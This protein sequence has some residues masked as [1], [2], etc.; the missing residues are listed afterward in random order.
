M[1]V[2]RGPST[3]GGQPNP[4]AI[5]LMITGAS[6]SFQRISS[7]D[8][9]YALVVTGTLRL[10]GLDGLEIEGT[11][12]FRVNTATGDHTFQMDDPATTATESSFVVNR[13]SFVFRATAIRIGVAGVLDIT[14]N[15]MV[16]RQPNGDLDLAITGASVDVTVDDTVVVRLGGYAAFTISSATGFRLSTFGVTTFA[17]FP[18]VAAAAASTTT[19]TSTPAAPTLFPTADLANPKNRS[20]VVY[21]T[22]SNGTGGILRVVFNDR[23]GVG[24]KETSIRDVAPEFEIWVN[25]VKSTVAI[26]TM[27]T[28]VAGLINTWDYTFSGNLFPTGG[29]S[30]VVEVRFVTGGISDNSG[31]GSFG[32]SEQFYV[33]PSESQKPGPVAVL[34]SPGNGE[35][36]TAPALNA[37]RYIDVTFTSLDGTPIRK[38]SIEDAAPEFKLVG[39]G[40]QDVALDATGAPI[41]VGLPLLISGRDAGATVVTYRFFLRDKTPNDA[42]GLFKPGTVQVAFLGTAANPA[43]TTEEY[44]GSVTDARGKN[45]VGLTQTFTLD[46]AAPGAKTQAGPISLG[47]LTLQ[48]PSV[49]IADVGFADGMLVLTISI[50]VDQASLAFGG[51]STTTPGQPT[52]TQQNSGVS[53]DLVGLQG[54]F[55]LA[56]DALGLLSGNV[57]IAPTGKW[58]IRVASLE[59]QVGNVAKLT[60]EGVVFGYTPRA[61]DAT[62]P[63]T[64]ELL[65][66]ATATITF[67]TLG[68]TGSLRP[69]DPSQGINVDPPAEGELAP[70][71]MPGLVV[72]ANGFSLGTAELA[73]GLPPFPPGSAPQPGNQLTKSPGAP[74][75][76]K[77]INL[78]GLIELDDLR[79][80]VQGLSVTFGE[81]ATQAAFTGTIY[82]ATG[83]ARLFPG[84]AINA[85]IKDRLTADDKNADLSDN[86]EALRAQLV[87]DDGEIKAFQLEIDTLEV[88]LSTFVT[89]TARDFVLDTGADAD[90]YLVS[91]LSVG[92]RIRVGGLELSGEARNFGFLGDGSFDAKANF[93]VYLG[94][95]SAT[96]DSFKWPDFLPVR[97]DAI[98][99]EWV[100]VENHPEDFV[101]VLSAS[102]TGIKGVGG[103]QFTG[104]IEGVRIAPALLAQGQFPIISIDSLGVTVKGKMFGGEIEAGL[105]GGI[106][107]L[108]AQ[109]NPIGVFDRTTPVAK[110]VFYLGIQGGFS[111]AGMAGFT[112]R[113]GLSELG[114]LQVFIN[115]EVP[116]GILLE[117]FSGLTINDFSAGVEFFKTLPSIDDPMALRGSAFGLPTNITADEWLASLQTQVANQAKAIRD[118]VAGDGFA[119]AFTSPMVITGAARIYSMYTSQAIFNGHVLVKISTDGKFLIV[120]TLNFAD[121]NISL[122]GR[123]Y[124]DLSRADEGDVTVLFLADI[125]DQARLLSL[126]GKLKMGFRNSS[127]QEV[128]FTVPAS[129]LTG[130]TTGSAAGRRREP[131]RQRRQHRPRSAE[132]DPDVG[133]LDAAV[134]HR[135]GVHRGSG[136]DDG[137]AADPERHDDL[138]PQGQRDPAGQWSGPHRSGHRQAHPAGERHH[139]GR[140]QRGRDHGRHGRRQAVGVLR[141]RRSQDRRGHRVPGRRR[142][143]GRADAGGG[144]ADQWL[145]PGPL[146]DRCRRHPAGCGL[147][148]LPRRSLQERGHSRGH[149]TGQRGDHAQLLGQGARRDRHRPGSR[150]QHR[151]ARAQRARV[152]R[153]HLH[154]P[155]G[156]HPGPGLDRRPGARVP[157]LGSGPRHGRPRRHPGPGPD[158]LAE[159]DQQL[160]LPL[161]H[162]R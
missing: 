134:L 158:Q 124:A 103:L 62:G 48:G 139:R 84:K 56:V 61:A 143:H 95:G 70:G 77:N 87:F 86:T 97:I 51:R 18:D 109:L 82:I 117:P 20:T 35:T 44:T 41:L 138:R 122:S 39:T 72:R 83:G 71:L 32:E 29:T 21:S 67:P 101:L 90:E 34:A 154:R 11:V 76:D 157:H 102:V 142:G 24:I 141:D 33:T 94:I 49:G 120:G 128:V 16:T 4:N 126:Y 147:P 79:V 92:A 131:G 146:P 125:P 15:L 111:I 1:F 140:C 150:R 25:G 81:G 123:L 80:G 85:T 26:G 112:I 63:D 37:R 38:S 96:G 14:G 53:V 114:P 6:V 110:R 30:G 104:S 9:T 45:I 31:A 133:V 27:P 36:L 119:A 74:G 99:V 148:V 42:T 13:Q 10:V 107:R 59:A 50:G 40:L 155:D 52:Q 54:T 137:L 144:H 151:R 46:A 129:D 28:P 93:G 127:G 115:V 89:L 88:N 132:E 12:D 55:D 162:H 105:V 145:Q 156:P 73:Y 153:R 23:N 5:G 100:D 136:R 135:P 113:I 64:Q 69:Y 43:W 98:G 22:F 130:G 106:M 159:R 160:H 152:D 3:I 8:G 7:T 108:D 68:V 17:L 161:L 2:G 19:T 47:P 75:T 149:R 57:R 78:F 65:R 58:G 118:G 60:A 91:F 66:I 121:N 116:G